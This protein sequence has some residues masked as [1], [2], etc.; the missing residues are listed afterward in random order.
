[1][2]LA[3]PVGLVLALVAICVG[4]IME[5]GDPLVMVHHPAPI[6]IV[7]GGTVGVALASN[8]L[9]DVAGVVKAIVRH[10]LPGKGSDA[11]AEVD[12][13]VALADTARRDGLLA[14]EEK[15]TD[16]EDPFLRRGL[17]L[18]IDGTDSEEVAE[19]LEAD[20]AGQK[21]RHKVAAKFCADCGAYAPTIGIIGTVLG[22]VHALEGLDDPSGLGKTI[23][24][25]FLATLW[26]VM[27][28]NCF[29]LPLSAKMKRT[30][31]L[32]VAHREMMLNGILALQAGAAPRAVGERLKSHLAPKQR[33]KVGGDSAAARAA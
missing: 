11:P 23:A 19:T 13:L 18:V 16:I 26:G 25:A 15:V 14:L 31:G 8:R 29:W 9:T 28:A 30:S 20:I 5:G 7:L 3:T 1:M 2:E 21:E 17:E 24:S 12:R 4:Y 32:E 10:L 6:V 33:E 27:S 22:L